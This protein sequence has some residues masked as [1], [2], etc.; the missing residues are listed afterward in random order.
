[1]EPVI[2]IRNLTAQYGDL[3]VLENINADIYPGEITVILG[4][5]GCGKTTLIKNILRLV[6]PVAGSVK[7]WG[8][9]VLGL[10]DIQMANILRKVGMLFQSG[11][12]LNS[13]SIYENISIPLELHTKLP[14]SLIDRIIKVKLNLVNLSEALYKFPSEL[15]GGMKKRAALARAMALDPQILFCDEPSAGLD[16]LTSAALDEL[17]LSLKKQLKM[18]IVVVTHELASIHRIADKIIFLEQGKMLFMGTLAEAQKAG[19]PQIDTFFEVG[20]F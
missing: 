11:A 14:R 2:T 7:F 13:L 9:E 1:M 6:E 12:L 17:I 18:T 3:I 4:G 5:S 10:D 19:I 8:E 16:P 20:R 15:S